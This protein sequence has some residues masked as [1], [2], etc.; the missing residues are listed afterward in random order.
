MKHC[1]RQGLAG[2]EQAEPSTQEQG[3]HTTPDRRASKT[4][5]V[6]AGSE[7]GAGRRGGGTTE[8]KTRDSFEVFSS[9]RSF[10]DEP[11]AEHKKLILLEFFVVNADIPEEL[12]AVCRSSHTRSTGTGHK[13]I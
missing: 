12:A 11:A 7:R 1:L 5:L 9:L 3:V 8:G 2:H 13:S 6:R 10:M 4:L